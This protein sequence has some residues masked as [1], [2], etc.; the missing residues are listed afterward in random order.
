MGFNYLIYTDQNVANTRQ[1][2]ITDACHFDDG[3]T[4]KYADIIQHPTLQEWAMIVHPLY[5]QYFTSDEIAQ[6]VPLTSDWTPA[7]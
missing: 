3:V 1:Q 7:S 5:L 4:I 2:Q 6:A